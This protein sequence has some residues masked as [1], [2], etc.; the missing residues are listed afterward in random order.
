MREYIKPILICF[1]GLLVL[2]CLLLIFT[3]KKTAKKPYYAYK[4]NMWTYP[5]KTGDL[6]LFSKKKD[7]ILSPNGLLKR[8]TGTTINH[9]GVIYVEPHSG[10]IY[11][12]DMNITGPRL[13]SLVSLVEGP[14]GKAKNEF[15]ILVRPLNK[16]ASS[17]QFKKIITNRND[18]LKPKQSLQ[19]STSIYHLT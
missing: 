9:V 4:H 16:S 13:A 17:S 2:V 7:H 5:F 19:S 14:T 6:I 18:H 1:L 10:H 15:F 3:I 12:W 11:V 8:V